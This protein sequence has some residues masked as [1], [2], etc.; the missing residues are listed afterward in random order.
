MVDDVEQFRPELEALLL[1]Y[2]E[3]LA[4]AE[5][6]FPESGVA[7]DV[8]RLLAEGSGRGLGEGGLIEPDASFTNG[9]GSNEGSPTRFQN[10][11][12]LPAPTPA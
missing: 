8:A 10:W 9:V 4:N 12:P 2:R 3:V 7:K 11:F 5:V 1:R 6:P